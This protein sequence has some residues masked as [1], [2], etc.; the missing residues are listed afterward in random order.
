MAGATA[1]PYMV[2]D[3]Q[4]EWQPD[5]NVADD[6]V[7]GSKPKF[8]FDKSDDQK[9]WLFKYPIRRGSGE[10]WA[11]KIAAEVARLLGVPHARIELAIF[12]NTPDE[13]AARVGYKGCISESFTKEGVD[14]LFHGNQILHLVMPDYDTKAVRF[15]Q[16]HHTLNNI[17]L[18]LDEV[19]GNSVEGAAAKAQFA[20]Y[21]T[22]DALIG[23]TDRHHENWGLLVSDGDSGLRIRLAQTYDHASC[24]GH[25]LLDR[26][27][28]ELLLSEGRIGRYAT[29]TGGKKGSGGIYWSSDKVAPSPLNLV[30]LA[31]ETEA[32]SESFESSRAR[33]RNLD[34]NS[35]CEVVDKV[36]A[37]WMSDA[38]RKF[39]ITLMRYNLSEL[40]KIL[41]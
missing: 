22:L 12:E 15:R 6:E 5:W 8:W 41:G 10:H 19:F 37:D 25:G 9:R 21:L 13:L 26:R 18:A 27:R 32:Y 38:A 28:G 24:L 30:R 20:G 29:G 2:I 7:M 23:N 35:L 39:A 17:W 4:V 40:R 33:I 11:E 3:V 14:G 36:P 31:A 16:P 1:E 34:E